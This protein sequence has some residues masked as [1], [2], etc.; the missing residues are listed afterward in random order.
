DNGRLKRPRKKEE[1]RTLTNQQVRWL[2]EGLS[3]DQPKAI[4][5][6]KKGSF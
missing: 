2:L 3:V 4:S 6:G 5:P 1:I